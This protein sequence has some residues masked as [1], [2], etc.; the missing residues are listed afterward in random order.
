MV[1]CYA[2][3]LFNILLSSLNL[4]EVLNLLVTDSFMLQ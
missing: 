3:V 4:A 2:S 1:K